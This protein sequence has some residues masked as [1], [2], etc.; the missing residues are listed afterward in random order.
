MGGDAEALAKQLD[1]LKTLR[2]MASQL[3]RDEVA[4]WMDAFDQGRLPPPP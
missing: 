1:N 3:K 2:E 4:E